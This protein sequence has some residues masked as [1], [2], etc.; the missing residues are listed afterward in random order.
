[1]TKRL[2]LLLVLYSLLTEGSFAQETSSDDYFRMA[3]KA[4]FEENNYTAAILLSKQAL[5]QS[6]GYTDI[7][8]FLGR[9]YYWSGKADS[10]MLILKAALDNNPAYEDA[11][12]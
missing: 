1:M 10:S 2:I 5:E 4:A 11:A 3:R 7:E 9:V 12:V 8:L 6:P